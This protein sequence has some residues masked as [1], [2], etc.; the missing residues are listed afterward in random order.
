M[1][2]M[3]ENAIMK[4]SRFPFWT[5]LVLQRC[6]FGIEING[7]NKNKMGEET[8]HHQGEKSSA[9]LSFLGVRACVACNLIVLNRKSGGENQV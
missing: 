5:C 7:P 8:C 2:Q 3:T 6:H 4:T 9:F 1:G